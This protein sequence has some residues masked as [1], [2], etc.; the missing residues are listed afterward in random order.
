MSDKIKFIIPKKEPTE[1]QQLKA[2]QEIAMQA[3]AELTMIIAT[4]Q[5]GI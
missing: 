2:E 4:L 5:G 1:L 3:I